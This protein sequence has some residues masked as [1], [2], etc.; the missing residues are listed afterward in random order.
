MALEL[1]TNA[2]I[3]LRQQRRL[4]EYRGLELQKQGQIIVP[5]LLLGPLQIAENVD[6]INNLGISAVLSV[7]GFLQNEIFSTG[8]DVER[9]WICVEDRV[10][11]ET[12]MKLALPEATETI[13]TWIRDRNRVVYVHCQSGISRSATVV[14]A[15]LMK[16]HRLP[17]MDC[18]KIV[19][20][21]RPV[22]TQHIFIIV[23]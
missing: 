15:Y 14:I 4:E 23:R 19:H 13:H 11:A 7:L 5:N 22:R 12:Q 8:A 21:A 3:A 2:E 6:D 17:L 16:Y 20:D 9:K 10:E 1:T 18:Y